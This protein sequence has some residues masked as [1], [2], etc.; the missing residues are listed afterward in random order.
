MSSKLCKERWIKDSYL[1]WHVAC[2]WNTS[3]LKDAWLCQGSP[4]SSRQES[5]SAQKH[6]CCCLFV[7]WPRSLVIW[8]FPKVHV[9][10]GI[11]HCSASSVFGRC[12]FSGFIVETRI[13]T[14]SF[15]L[16]SL[17]NRNLE[18]F[19]KLCTT[20]NLPSILHVHCKYTVWLKWNYS[21]RMNAVSKVHNLPLP[22]LKKWPFWMRF[23]KSALSAKVSF[24]YSHKPSSF[25]VP[26]ACKHSL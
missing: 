11:S 13:L 18:L 5:I 2:S 22:T 26:C 21:G 25:P 9:L 14:K 12:L 19:P 16:I 20:D 1:D 15:Q 6:F 23:S 17:Q 3:C 24:K 4:Q 7:P 8:A 10:V